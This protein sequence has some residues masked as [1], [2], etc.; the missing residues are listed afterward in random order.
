VRAETK[1]ENVVLHVLALPNRIL[2]YA[3]IV[4]GES[5][6]KRKNEVFTIFDIAEPNPIFYKDSER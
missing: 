2:S 5:N 6:S 1:Q 4:K 3:K